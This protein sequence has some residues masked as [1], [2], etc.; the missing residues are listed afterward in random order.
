M[1]SE[2]TDQT[3]VFSRPRSSTPGPAEGLILASASPRRRELLTEA[4]IPFDVFP[5]DV[6]ETPLPGEAPLIYASRVACDKAT[7]IA[8]QY[9]GRWVLGADTVVVVDNQILGKPCSP[10]EACGMLRLL[11]DRQHE[12]MTAV[13]LVHWVSQTSGLELDEFSVTSEVVFRALTEGEICDYVST[14][15]PMDK[16]GAYAIQGGAAAFVERY[17]GSWSNIV[18]LPLEEVL[19]H[20]SQKMTW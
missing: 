19:A 2:N 13:A 1:G 6:D 17:E 9:P 4:G 18:G 16:A 12:V 20:L 15:E 3:G 10:E 11:S 7:V 5:A 14:G 8:K